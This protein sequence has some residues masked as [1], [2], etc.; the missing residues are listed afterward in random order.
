MVS[1]A[2][3]IGS[4]F[5]L[6]REILILVK[7]FFS[8]PGASLLDIAFEFFDFLGTLFFDNLFYLL[9]V[10]GIYIFYTLTASQD[11]PDTLLS[12]SKFLVLYF[13]EIFLIIFF[14]RLF[15]VLISLIFNIF[16]DLVL[17]SATQCVSITI[18]KFYI[19]F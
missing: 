11:F 13:P 15:F 17:E 4:L 16:S 2:D 1:S 5:Y 14:Y 7:S 6:L 18:N 9:D 3:T 19:T 12:H 10:L 8:L